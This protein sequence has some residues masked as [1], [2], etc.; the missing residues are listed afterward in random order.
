MSAAAL[1]MLR[2]ILKP[3]PSVYS[4]P[5]LGSRWRR[6]LCD[7]ERAETVLKI[8]PEAVTE[9]PKGRLISVADERGQG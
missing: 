1:R 4:S 3:A 6:K 2:S 8:E 9:A 7:K 5:N